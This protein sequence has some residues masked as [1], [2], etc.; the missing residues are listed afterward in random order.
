MEGVSHR[1]PCKVVTDNNSLSFVANWTLSS[2][3]RNEIPFE[4]PRGMVLLMVSNQRVSRRD[5]ELDTE[6]GA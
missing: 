1:V 2:I 3:F 4:I 6:M 5:D